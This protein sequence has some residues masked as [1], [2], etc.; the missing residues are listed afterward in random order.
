LECDDDRGQDGE[1][2]GDEERQAV[3][4]GGQNR[5]PDRRACLLAGGEQRSGQTLLAGLDAA[6]DGDRRRRQRQPDPGPSDVIEI[7]PE[8]SD[9]TALTPPIRLSGS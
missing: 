5:Q 7:I 9:Y 4:G 1:A 8:R 3:A 2:G 6:G